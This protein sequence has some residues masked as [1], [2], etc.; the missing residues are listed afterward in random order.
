VHIPHWIPQSRLYLRL[1]VLRNWFTI[2]KGS[3]LL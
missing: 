3:I 1:R 2:R